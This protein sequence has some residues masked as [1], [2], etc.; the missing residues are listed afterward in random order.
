MGITWKNLTV[1][2]QGTGVKALD[3]L[4]SLFKSPSFSNIKKP[5]LKTILDS[6]EGDLQPGELLLVLRRPGAGCTSFLKTLASYR[7]G[8]HSVD[9]DITYSG[10][11]AKDIQGPYRGEVVCTPE[12]E[13]CVEM[14]M[15][16]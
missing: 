7:D 8:F 4:S 2:G 11:S 14:M 9:G 6:F 10:L 12:G 1:R 15:Q 13:K 3:S 16:R 5:H